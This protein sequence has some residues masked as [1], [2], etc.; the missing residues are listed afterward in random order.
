M[1]KAAGV[2]EQF[3]AT[4]QMRW[5]GLPFFRRKIYSNLKKQYHVTAVS[6]IFEKIERI[7][8]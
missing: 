6:D 4:D 1:G 2:T 3:K 7:A 5:E 8:S